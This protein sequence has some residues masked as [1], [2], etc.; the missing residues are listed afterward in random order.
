MIDLHCLSQH[1]GDFSRGNCLTI[2]AFLV[3]ANLLATLQT[4]IFWFLGKPSSY[5][6]STTSMGFIYATLMLLHVISWYVV[7]VVMAPT[8]ILAGLAVVC[9]L[10]N[11][12]ALWWLK[13]AQVMAQVVT[14]FFVGKRITHWA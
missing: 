4:M 13:N 9:L 11:G 2:C 6:W 8:F 10:I 7:G 1:L 3:P 14:G 12:G 5:I